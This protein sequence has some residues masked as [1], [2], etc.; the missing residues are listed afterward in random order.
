MGSLHFQLK[1]LSYFVEG[2]LTTGPT[3]SSLDKLK[4]QV[5]DGEVSNRT[6]MFVL[7]S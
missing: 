7:V 6:Q 4:G 5:I 1:L 3:P 2:L